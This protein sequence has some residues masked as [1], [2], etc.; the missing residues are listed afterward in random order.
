MQSVMAR[1]SAF[2]LVNLAFDGAL[3]RLLRKW[4]AAGDTYEQIARRLQDLK[5]IDVTSS[6]VRRWCLDLEEVA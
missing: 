3:P 2:P 4:R 6:T 5:G 1:T